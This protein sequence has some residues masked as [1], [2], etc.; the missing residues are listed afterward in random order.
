M[1][2]T[3]HYISDWVMRT[4]PVRQYEVINEDDEPEDRELYSYSLVTDAQRLNLFVIVRD[5]A[6][7]EDEFEQ[8]VLEFLDENGFNTPIN[9]PVKLFHSD[10]CQYADPN[11]DFPYCD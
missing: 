2:R 5:V 8:E 1:P 11:P 7:F 10:E 6:E 9:S 3:T 4:G